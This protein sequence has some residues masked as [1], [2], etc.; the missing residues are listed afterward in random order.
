MLTFLEGPI[1]V[2]AY[3]RE[4]A[5]TDFYGISEAKQYLFKSDL[6]KTNEK[7]HNAL[8]K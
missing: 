3:L 5:I 6:E 1:F 4:G 7:K 2:R 8:K